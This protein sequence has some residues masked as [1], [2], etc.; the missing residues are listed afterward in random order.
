MGGR[1]CRSE[2]ESSATIPFGAELNLGIQIVA[3]LLILVGVRYAILTHR[4]EAA[5]KEEG[6]RFERVHKNLMTSAVVVSGIGTIIWM[7]P[8]LFLGWFYGSNFMGYGTGGVSSYLE[9]NGAYYAHSYLIVLMVAVG[10]VTAILGVYLVLRMR[11]SGFPAALKV[12]NYRAVMIA[13]WIL[14]VVNVL[15]GLLVFYFFAVLGT[16]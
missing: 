2:E 6:E 5:G 16:G 14:W 4:F 13:T 10:A 12:Q 8:N 3:F 15:I 7:L 9:Y 11:W 1:T